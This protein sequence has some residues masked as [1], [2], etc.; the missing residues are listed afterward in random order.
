MPGG[1]SEGLSARRQTGF[2]RRFLK[3]GGDGV[4]I[5]LDEETQWQAPG[6]GQVHRLQN[7]PDVDRAIA[8]VADRD[9]IRAGLLVGEGGT[10]RQRHAAADDRVGAERSRLVPPQM[11][12]AAAPAAKA[13]RKPH[14]LGERAAKKRH[15]GPVEVRTHGQSAR[16]DI[17]QGLCQKLVVSA[18]RTVDLVVR[19]QRQD[20]S[21]GTAFLPIDECAGPCT[22]PSFASSSTA[23]SKA[24]MRWRDDRTVFSSAVSAPSQSFLVVPKSSQRV[25][26]DTFFVCGISSLN[27]Q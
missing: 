19:P 21:N 11:H 2:R 7:R 18:M 5:V 15:D 12:G 16:R 3:A 10:R 27:G 20:G 17:V 6:G 1:D 9:G 13:F 26:L 14:D 8:E 24:R 4:T 23:S 22:S 25:E